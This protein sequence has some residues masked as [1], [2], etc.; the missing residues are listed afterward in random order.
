[1]ESLYLAWRYLLFHRFKTILLVLSLTLLFFVP[2]GLR[3]L[4]HQTG[5][6]LQRRAATTPIL[7]GAKGSSLDLVLSGLYFEGTRPEPMTEAQVT[8]VQDSGLALA[9]P[10]HLGFEAQHQPIVGTSPDYLD[11]RGLR[12]AA[13]RRFVHLGECIL[14][15]RAAATLALGPGSTLVSSPQNLFDLAGVYPL[16]MKVVGVLAAS[17]TPDDRAVFV[18]LK[19]AWVIEGLGHG[20]EDLSTDEA[21][22]AV[23]ARKGQQITANASVMQYQRITEKNRD[24]FH[25]HGDEKDFPVT[26]VLAVPRDDKAAALLMG[27]YLSKGETAQIV[28]PSAV[29]EQLMGTV[30]TVQG[31]VIA[32]VVLVGLSTL[33]TAFLVFL[34]SWRLRRGEIETMVRIGASKGRI[35]ALLLWELGFVL[36]LSLFLSALLVFFTASQGGALLRRLLLT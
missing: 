16:E 33:A 23:L 31:Y 18:D 26:A 15:S 1:M 36:S 28:E 17:G 25:F 35:R 9:I 32:A 22:G 7:I 13:G 3:V 8:R 27:R 21:A 4:V 29:L 5:L 10:L 19:T 12:L 14:G 2:V 30:F 34:L 24:S 11:F 20:H 6:E